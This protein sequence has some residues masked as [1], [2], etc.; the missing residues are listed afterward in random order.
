MRKNC[1]NG[2]KSTSET[3]IRKLTALATAI[4]HWCNVPIATR[5]TTSTFT[6]FECK[7]EGQTDVKAEDSLPKD[8][9]KD[10]RDD[11]EEFYRIPIAGERESD[12]EESLTDLLGDL[13]DSDNEW[14]YKDKEDKQASN[15]IAFAIGPNVEGR[16]MAKNISLP[17]NYLHLNPYTAIFEE[18]SKSLPT[19]VPTWSA[20]VLQYQRAGLKQRY[21]RQRRRG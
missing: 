10:E 17:R 3:T 18:D 7:Q 11:E 16:V 6:C 20:V 19:E 12:Y 1:N 14:I 9:G 2:K 13:S 4:C 8:K 15:N 21:K 5:H